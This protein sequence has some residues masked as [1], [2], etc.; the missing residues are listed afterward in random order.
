MNDAIVLEDVLAVGVDPHRESLDLIGIRFPEEIVLDETFDNTPADHRALLS[1]ARE[2]VA[3]HELALV[4]GL[5][6]SGN[7]GYTLG[8]YLA[9]QGCCVKEINPRMTSRQRDFPA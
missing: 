9:E 7:Y 6:D 1:E 2:L 4:F 5:E 3:E 8:R